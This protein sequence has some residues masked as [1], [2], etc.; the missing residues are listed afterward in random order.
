MRRLL[1]GRLAT[2]LATKHIREDEEKGEKR[3]R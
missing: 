1:K 3:T 2:D